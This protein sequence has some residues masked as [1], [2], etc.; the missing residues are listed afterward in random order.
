MA[1]EI[2]S[3]TLPDTGRSP[4]TQHILSS[5]AIGPV[6]TCVKPEDT[7][8]LCPYGLRKLQSLGHSLSASLLIA[9][10]ITVG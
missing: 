6:I 8:L 2:P 5:K 9:F 4:T 3:A 7:C 10:T 1:T